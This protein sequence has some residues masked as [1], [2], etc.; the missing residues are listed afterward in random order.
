MVTVIVEFGSVDPSTVEVF[1]IA[2]PFASVMEVIIGAS[3]SIV[4]FVA[5]D[6]LPIR[7]V[8]VTATA[9]L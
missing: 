2:S 9:V 8:L 3:A 7:S 6:S 4:T 1:E 5:L